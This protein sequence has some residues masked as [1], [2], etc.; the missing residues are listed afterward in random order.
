M[1]RQVFV[2][3]NVIVL[4]LLVTGCAADTSHL[5]TALQIEVPQPVPVLLLQSILDPEEPAAPTAWGFSGHVYRAPKPDTSRPVG[6]VFIRFVGGPSTTGPWSNLGS[7]KTDA[8]GVFTL[9][10]TISH[11]HYRVILVVPA[12]HT[13][14]GSEAGQGGITIGKTVIRF[15]NPDSGSYPNN[16]FWIAT[17]AIYLPVALKRIPD[18][19]VDEFANTYAQ[20]TIETPATVEMTGPAEPGS[21]TAQVIELNGPTTVEVKMGEIGD[22]DS[23]GLDEV[24]TE[25]V[26]LSLTGISPAGSLTVTVRSP[27]KS[28]FKR[29]TGEIEENQNTQTGRL[30][31]PPYGEEGTATSFFDVYFQVEVAGQVL[32]AKEPKRMTTTITRIPPDEGETYFNPDRIR[33][34]FEDETPS[35]F[36]IGNAYHT[37][38]PPAEIDFFPATIAF[39][40]VEG[41]GGFREFVRGDGPTTVHVFFL[42]GE[43]GKANDTD[44]NGKDQVQTEIVSMSLTGNSSLAGPIVVREDP[45]RRSLGEIEETVNI[46]SGNLDIQPFANQGVA[47]SY[48]DVYFEV[49]FFGQTYHT[50]RPKHMTTKITHKPPDKGTMYFNPDRIRLLDVNNDPTSFFITVAYHVPTPLD[51]SPNPCDFDIDFS[52]LRGQQGDP[53]VRGPIEPG[54]FLWANTPGG[55]IS[56]WFATKEW[57]EQSSG[58][59][60]NPQYS[61]MDLVTSGGLLSGGQQPGTGLGLNPGVVVFDNRELTCDPQALALDFDIQ[62]GPASLQVFDGTGLVL[63][64]GSSEFKVDEP[65]LFRG[66]GTGGPTDIIGLAIAAADSDVLLTHACLMPLFPSNGDFPLIP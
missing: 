53:V 13:A 4:T 9:S 20:V 15:D 31:L 35:D 28:P 40:T 27:D 24:P 65:G 1:K 39:V 29:S 14:V 25:I 17:N 58:K 3:L 62:Q 30:D 22:K 49:E 19:R 63:H 43:E 57:I 34:F 12:G 55:W 21:I 7:T 37:P 11:P 56:L 26:A 60:L 48:F 23:D 61:I 8:S 6:D 52:Q 46:T 38:N 66:L 64:P 18:L 54:T 47:A 33:L 59:V 42:N 44:S 41:P 45:N 10:T 36:F 5:T 16:N 50:E 32:H 51:K 2:L